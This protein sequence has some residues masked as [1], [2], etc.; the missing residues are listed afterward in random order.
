MTAVVILPHLL[1]FSARVA[2]ELRLP[3]VKVPH[4]GTQHE[5]P[6]P[7]EATT[8]RI[9]VPAEILRH[10]PTANDWSDIDIVASHNE[11]L[12]R[13]VNE[14]IGDTWREATRRPKRIL[15]D[16]LL[17]NSALMADLVEQY[18][19]RPV[20]RY[21]FRTDP[22]G[23]LIWHAIA[24]D[25]AT[26][27]PFS[28]PVAGH[29]SGEQVLEVVQAICQQFKRLTEANGLVANLYNEDRTLRHE[30]FAQRLFYGIADSYCEANDLDLS[31]EC[32]AGR[33][34][35]DFKVSGGYHNRV[36]VEVKYTSNPALQRGYTAQLPI[37]NAA[38]RAAESVY[39]VIQTTERSVQLEAIKKLERER[40]K[41][42]KQSPT[43]IVV[44][45]RPQP[46]ASKARTP[47]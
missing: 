4:R 7:S 22:A 17:A 12:R 16:I 42:G 43:I 23:E 5:I 46:S 1:A 3:T 8:G 11:V 21:D 30:R 6:R 20:R 15:R 24:R 28:A 31:P 29:I 18:K 39:L 10:L 44:D 38:E 19:A 26:R 2:Q 33:G 45:G 32:N 34:S 9:L 13:A 27:F 36:T 37:Y 35:V 25:Y 41:A 14:T 40:R 47:R